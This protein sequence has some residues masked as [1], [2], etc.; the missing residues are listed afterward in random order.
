MAVFK[1]EWMEIGDSIVVVGGD[2][3]FNCHIHTD[4]IGEAIEAG[5]RAGRPFRLQITDL[6]D[7]AETEAQ[8]HHPSAFEPLPA[9]AAADIGVVAVA[10]GGGIVEMFRQ[11]GVQGVVVGGQT[12][13]PSTEE[14]LAAVESVPAGDVVVLPNNKNIIPVAKQLD[15]LTDK[16][17]VCVPT[18]SVP[19]G[20]A[21][22]VSYLPTGQAI[23]VVASRMESAMG[24]VASGEITR[25]VRDVEHP[26]RPGTRRATGWDSSAAMLPSSTPSSTRR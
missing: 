22:M 16:K 26:G 14:L 25:A 6:L 5:I 8:H 15:A 23:G 11:L 19:E 3:T 4:D 13:N 18:R 2:G 1:R 20:L 21:A 9:F 24:D 7:Q 17:V 12:M 10:V